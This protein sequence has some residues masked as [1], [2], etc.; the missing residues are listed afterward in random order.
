MTEVIH[1]SKVNGV[2][3]GEDETARVK[4]IFK[5]IVQGSSHDKVLDKVEVIYAGNG[6]FIGEMLIEPEH[7][8]IYGS[9]HGGF[10]ATLI[11][12]C[13]SIAMSTH[14]RK[15]NGVSVDLN[16]S[17][18]KPGLLNE[19]IVITADTIRVGKTMGFSEAVITSKA[20]GDILA[21]GMHTKY[22]DSVKYAL[23]K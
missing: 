3:E 20:S 10:T 22:V 4:D 23:T 18:L 8:N 6:R 1:N 21:K 15:G 5:K 2:T 13:T 17:Y 7:T 19:R 14:P 16:I 9:L 12:I 11:D